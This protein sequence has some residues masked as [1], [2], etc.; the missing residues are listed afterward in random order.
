MP[1]VFRQNMGV[2]RRLTDAEAVPVMKAAGLKP[3]SP[4]RG[5]KDIPCEGDKCGSWVS[6]TYGTFA[7]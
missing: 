6:P 5:N 3:L 2:A 1:V 7:Q 4:Y